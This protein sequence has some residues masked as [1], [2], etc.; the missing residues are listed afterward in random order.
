[1]TLRTIGNA[2]AAIRPMVR[3]DALV[4]AVAF[5]RAVASIT[6]AGSFSFCPARLLVSWTRLIRM[7]WRSRSAAPCAAVAI[8]VLA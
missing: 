6:A 1:M 5:A 3:K 4:E 8:W 2:S 7:F